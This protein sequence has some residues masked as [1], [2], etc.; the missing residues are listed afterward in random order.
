VQ[1]AET[2]LD[3]AF[4]ALESYSGAQMELASDLLSKRE[5]IVRHLRR[6]VAN[7]IGA[8]CTRIHGDFHLGQVLVAGTDVVIIDFEGEPLKSLKERRAKMS[9]MRDVAGMIRSFDYAAGVVER[10]GQLSASGLGHARAH[11]LLDDF[12]R[13]AQ[14][15]FLAGYDEGR[16]SALTSQEQKLV[17]AFAIE[18]AAY[19]ITYEAANRPDWI[20]IPLRGLSALVAG[21]TSSRELEHAE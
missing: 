18:K 17:T 5:D 21:V 4:R 11:A 8:L 12:R 6:L 7:S 19:E 3:Q 2:Q 16:G 20:D 10:E 14:T 13:T 9:P 15:A 1:Q